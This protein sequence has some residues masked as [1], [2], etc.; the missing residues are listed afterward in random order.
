M[1]GWVGVGGSQVFGAL[2]EEVSDCS[3]LWRLKPEKIIAEGCQGDSWCV[4]AHS[5]VPASV[6]V[7]P[8]G[9]EELLSSCTLL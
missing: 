1:S 7:P 9:L 3:E 8:L 4:L 2:A 6:S 5:S